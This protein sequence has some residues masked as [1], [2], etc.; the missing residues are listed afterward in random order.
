MYMYAYK[1][2]ILKNQIYII[3][4]L[5]CKISFSIV[6]FEYEYFLTRESRVRH[7]VI[8]HQ[9]K[10]YVIEKGKEREIEREKLN[11]KTVDKKMISICHAIDI[12]Y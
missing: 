9:F 5:L 6:Y 4:L 11:K 3:T 10:K 2:R 7:S 1:Y 12:T 8:Y